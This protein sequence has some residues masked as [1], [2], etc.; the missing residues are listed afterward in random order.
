[1]FRL[2]SV[3]ARGERLEHVSKGIKLIDGA[4]IND[5]LTA[6]LYGLHTLRGGKLSA[7][8]AMSHV[9][10]LGSSA[11]DAQRMVKGMIGRCSTKRSV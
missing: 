6:Y 1:M 2:C 7:A 10:D 3:S 11:Q 8:D 4:M 9:L 5:A